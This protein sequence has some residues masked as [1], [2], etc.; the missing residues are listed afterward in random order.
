MSLR[1][2]RIAVA[3]VMSAS[4]LAGLGVAESSGATTPDTTAETSGATTPDFDRR[5]ERPG[6][7]GD[8]RR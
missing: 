2:S 6:G 8:G 4:L 1:R 7:I 5:G 3:A